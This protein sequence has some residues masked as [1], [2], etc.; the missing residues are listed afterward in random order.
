VTAHAPRRGRANLYYYLGRECSAWTDLNLRQ[1]ESKFLLLKNSVDMVV[2]EPCQ[3][4]LVESTG[5]FKR[6]LTVRSEGEIRMLV[7][8]GRRV[9]ADE[10]SLH[11]AALNGRFDAEYAPKP[12]LR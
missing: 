8:V 5:R 7:Y 10:L 1:L 12:G 3:A 2:C 4:R 9:D 11:A 6:W